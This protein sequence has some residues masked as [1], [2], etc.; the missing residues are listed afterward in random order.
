MWTDHLDATLEE[1]TDNL[2][3]NCAG[4]VAA[5][6]RVHD[7]ALEM[8][9]LISAGVMKQFPQKFTGQQSTQRRLWGRG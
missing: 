6:D 9:G 5:Y 1:A 4:E 3:S 8:A 7:M 2:T